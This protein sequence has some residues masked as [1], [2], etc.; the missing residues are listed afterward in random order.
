MKQTMWTIGVFLF[1]SVRGSLDGKPLGV[2]LSRREPSCQSELR[3]FVLHLLRD[4][5]E[6][7]RWRTM[8]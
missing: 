8:A 6:L 2:D 1:P 4:G 5:L 3:G 7:S